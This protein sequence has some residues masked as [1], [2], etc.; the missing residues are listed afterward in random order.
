MFCF[1]A[2]LTICCESFRTTLLQTSKA[3][4]HPDMTSRE[5]EGTPARVHPFLL[6]CACLPGPPWALSVSFSP[7]PNDSRLLPGE[8][9]RLEMSLLWG[10]GNE[11][12]NSIPSC[13]KQGPG[14]VWWRRH[15]DYRY[16][17]LFSDVARELQSCTCVFTVFTISRHWTRLQIHTRPLL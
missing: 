8:S 7:R 12:T 3:P 10:V 16:S 14:H 2:A 9:V 11:D 15:K 17:R 5:A 6:T 13:L 4:N 1:C